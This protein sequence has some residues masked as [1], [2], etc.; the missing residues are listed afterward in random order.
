MASG[1]LE[2]RRRA[3]AA[4]RWAVG[5]TREYGPEGRGAPFCDGCLEEGQVEN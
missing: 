2:H 3:L 5:L 1:Y 4:I